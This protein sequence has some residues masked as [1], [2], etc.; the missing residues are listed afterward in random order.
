MMEWNKELSPPIASNHPAIW[1]LVIEDMRDRDQFGSSKYKTRLKGFDGR[2]SLWD[3]YQEILDLSVYIRKEIYEQQHAL[4][5]PEVK[6][7]KE[8]YNE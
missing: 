8:N 2:K 1:D 6:P 4:E 3:A 7:P 5:H